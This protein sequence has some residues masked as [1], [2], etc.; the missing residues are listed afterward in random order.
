MITYIKTSNSEK[1]KL[2]MSKLLD[3]LFFILNRNINGLIWLDELNL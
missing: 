2:V 1:A 3:S